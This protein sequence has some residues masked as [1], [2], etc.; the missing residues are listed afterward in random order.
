MESIRITEDIIE[1]LCVDKEDIENKIEYKKD[2]L[3][4]IEEVDEMFNGMIYLQE[5]HQ[6]SMF[7]CEEGC[8]K[9]QQE[10]NSFYNMY[11]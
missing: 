9:I 4:D 8:F 5:A 11:T 7:Y 2:Y 10:N 3:D 6:C 1:Q